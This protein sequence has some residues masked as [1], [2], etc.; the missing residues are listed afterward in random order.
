MCYRGLYELGLNIQTFFPQCSDYGIWH[1]GQQVQI[2]KKISFQAHKFM[3]K[4][5]Y[6]NNSYYMD[7]TICINFSQGCRYKFMTS[8]KGVI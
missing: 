2:Q 6:L 1:E 3:L 4:E 5:S 8:F 7:V